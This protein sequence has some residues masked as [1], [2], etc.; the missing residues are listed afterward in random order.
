MRLSDYV[1]MVA[2]FCVRPVVVGLPGERHPVLYLVSSRHRSVTEKYVS[3]QG[4]RLDLDRSGRVGD[5]L[6]PKNMSC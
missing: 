5:Y 6:G 1:G 4:A 2:F 3:D